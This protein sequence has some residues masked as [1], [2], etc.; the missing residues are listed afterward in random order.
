VASF[1]FD[2]GDFIWAEQSAGFS[3]WLAAPALQV[4][5]AQPGVEAET[6]LL[7]VSGEPEYVIKRWRRGF[8]GDARQQYEFLV[9]AYR[10]GL[11]VPEAAGWGSD[12]QGRQVL[13]TTFVGHAVDAFNNE[14]LRRSARLLA[15]IHALPAAEVRLLPLSRPQDPLGLS[16]ARYVHDL[17]A[18]PGVSSAVAHLRTT[19]QATP[20]GLVHGD[21]NLVNVLIKGRRLT[22]IDW[23]NVAVGDG[24]CDAAWATAVLRIYT[25]R[26]RSELFEREYTF[27]AGPINE[28]Q[29]T[30]RV[31]LAAVQWILF[32]QAFG[33]AQGP[34]H[35][36]RAWSL[37]AAA[38]P[39]SLAAALPRRSAHV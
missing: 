30:V 31:A 1:R 28:R 14:H 25:T 18:Y 13:A 35:G 37:A 4:H 5:R 36:E 20:P 2:P 22:A 9:E 33:V 3:R 10:L 8:R 16:F 17:G 34:E 24:R 29:W 38:L 12:E 19:I 15:R 6:L 27:A 26:E 32:D 11:P 23:T 39:L 21:F 7:A